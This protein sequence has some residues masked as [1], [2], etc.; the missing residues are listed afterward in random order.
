MKFTH[1]IKKILILFLLSFLFIPVTFGNEDISVDFFYGITCPHCKKVD[2]LIEE[3]KPLYP[4]IIFNEYEVYSN[5]DNST[6][7]NIYFDKY[8]VPSNQR[9]VPAVFISDQYFIGDTPIIDNLENKIKVL[10]KY[11][12]F[13]KRLFRILL[14]LNQ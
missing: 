1:L 2:P 11:N 4:E 7:L 8:D 13:L 14:Y 10:M 3:L 5:H 6:K 9:G 12:Q